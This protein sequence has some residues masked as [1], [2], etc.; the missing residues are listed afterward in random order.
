VVEAAWGEGPSEVGLEQG[1]NLPQV[2]ASAFDVDRDGT[3]H[4]LDEAHRRLLRWRPGSRV[5]QQVPLAI[6]GTL[7]DLSVADDGTIHVLESTGAAGRPALRIF[8][9]NGAPEAEAEIAERGA[10]VRIGPRGPVVLQYPS[11]QWMPVAID[12][13]PLSPAAQ[14]GAGRAGRQLT[15]GGEV[16][17]LRRENE[18]RVAVLDA[19]AV[20]RAW[21]ITSETPLAEVQLADPL[22]NRLVVVV[23]VYTDDRDE[24]VVLELGREGLRRSF[25]LDSADWAETSPLGRFRLVG[26]SLYQLGS[27]PAGIFVDRFDLGAR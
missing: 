23:R 11:S 16:V 3:V 24:F 15:G 7:A 22:R 1:R 20:L 12:G 25:S 27:T 17:V 21:R 4:V 6:N 9:A 8:E 10:H 13:R 18:I 26:S 5:P 2:G 14:R 19:R